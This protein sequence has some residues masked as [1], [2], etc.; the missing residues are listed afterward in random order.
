VPLV[1]LAGCGT[2]G[3]PL[4]PSLNL[5]NPVTDLTAVRTGN[6]VSLSWTTP[7]KN[8]DKLVMKDNVSVW[9][10][11]KDGTGECEDAG[12]GKL[13]LAPGANG[14][15]SETLPADLASGSPRTLSYYVELK[16]RSGRSAGKSNPAVVLAGAPPA[17]LTGMTAEVRKGGVVL[18]WT[19]NSEDL[20]VRLSRRLLTPPGKAQPPG[21][22][23]PPPEPIE[24]NLLVE[25][26]SRTGRAI[27]RDIRFGEAYEYRAQRVGRVTTDGKTLE[28]DGEL[29][30]AVRVEVRDVFPPAIPSG[31][32]AVAVA[33]RNGIEPAIDLSWR[34]D[35][36]TD[37]AGYIVYRKEG[38]AAWAR[39]SPAEPL[40]GPAYHDTHVE[41][42][43]TY[44]Y[45][46]SAVDQGGHESA[47]SGETQE[48]VPSN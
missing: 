3:A 23:A 37:I 17:P 36:E 16:N 41:P 11:R 31:L 1:V 28:L 6:Q 18:R 29:S 40:V 10:C 21:P 30:P 22:L 20:P 19:A 2:P 45:T 44:H 12:G 15:F 13:L 27:D 14:A 8:T 42:G 25:S 5:P 26:G 33:A 39:L 46:V 38:D 48:T 47:R 34:P 9:I 24:E 7:K 35:T 43:R 4:P 32:V